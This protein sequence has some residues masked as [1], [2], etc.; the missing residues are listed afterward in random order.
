MSLQQEANEPQKGV[1]G[2]V[3]SHEESGLHGGHPQ[4]GEVAGV[5]TQTSGPSD[6]HS[7]GTAIGD[8]GDKQT[9]GPSSMGTAA[10]ETTGIYPNDPR[11]S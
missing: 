3:G 4:G 6:S 5:G 11:L 7:I 10:S 9:T 8:K 1:Q 2:S